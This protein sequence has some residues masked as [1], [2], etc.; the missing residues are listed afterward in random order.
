MIE[1]TLLAGIF[2]GLYFSLMAMGL[3]LIFGVMKIINLAHGDFIMLGAFFSY[4]AY[5]YLHVSPWLVVVAAAAVLAAIG[6]ILYYPLVPRLLRSRDP[7][8][9]S[10]V[11]FFGLSQ[12]IEALAVIAF[13]NNPRSVNLPIMTS[14]PIAVL[15]QSFQASWILTAGVSTVAIGLMYL[16]L[17]RTRLG[18]ATRAVMGSRDEAAAS[19]LNVHR[20]SMITFGI[21]LALAAGAGVLAPL[22][23]GSIYP[24]MGIALTTTS[25]A[26]I[27]IGSL[28]NPAGT[29]LGGLIYGVSTMLM[30]TYFSSWSSMVPY[31]LLLLIVFLK[32]EGLL[33]KGVRSA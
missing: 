1:Y 21:G 28:G 12:V 24:S 11:L 25:F 2:F 22:M 23:L 19:G 18:F 15:G 26:V 29:L 14:H 7:E 4:L 30:E 6:F 33:G 8:M 20:V 9:L 13:G 10:L 5:Q 31:L 16:Y 17:Y 32:P 27:V 3:N